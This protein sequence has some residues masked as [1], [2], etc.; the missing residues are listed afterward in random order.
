MKYMRSTILLGL[1]VGS[2]FIL[3]STNL[4]GSSSDPIKVLSYNIE[5]SG[6]NADWKQVIKEENPDIAILVETGAFDDD[7][8]TL[9]D[10]YCKE[11]NDYFTVIGE[12]PYTCATTQDI[13]YETSGETI[14]TRYPIVSTTQIALLTLDDGSTHDPSHDFF[15]VL[16][17]I[18]TLDIHVIGAHLK[19]C[20]GE[21][22]NE[23][24]RDMQQEG[25]INYMDDLGDVPIMYMGDLNSFSPV[26]TEDPNL[27]PD[28]DDLGVGPMTMMIRPDDPTYG[29]YSSEIHTWIDVFRELNPSDPGYTYGHQSNHLDGRIDFIT[30]NQHFTMS[31]LLESTVGDTPTADTGSDHYAVDM[32]IDL[33]GSGDPDDTTPPAQVTGLTATASSSSQIDLAWDANSES[34]LSYYKV[35]RDGVYVAQISNSYTTYSDTGLTSDTTYTYEV[36]AVD[37]SGNEGTKSD[38]AS[39]TTLA[40]STG[41]DYVYVSS[42]DWDLDHINGK[43]PYYRLDAFITILDSSGNAVSGATVTIDWTLPDGSVTRMSATTDSNGVATF[44]VDPADEGTHTV[45][46]VDVVADLSYDPTQNVETT[47]S[48]TI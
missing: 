32:T 29:T 46:V 19:C 1:L 12:D 22:I 47:D 24:K 39:A 17:D 44:T 2:L 48:F 3:G 21:P 13:E 11:F 25:I 30:V 37:D 40:G 27:E 28:R 43:N 9:L 26:D 6:S 15:D 5:E 4:V 38:P 31:M 10:Q 20:S 41:D 33:G 35:Y 18:N 8:N 42:I 7:N 34:D 16:V 14:L 36:S 45:T 23:E